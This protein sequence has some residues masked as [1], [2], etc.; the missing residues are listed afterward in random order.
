MK[1]IEA[2]VGSR[3]GRAG[4]GAASVAS[5]A[6]VKLP[7]QISWTAY[8]T[9]SS[10]YAQSVGIGQ[11][12]KKNYGTGLRI[13]PGKNDVARM[14]PLRSG[15]TPLCACGIAAYFA[16]EGAYFFGTKKWGPMKLYNLLNNI[17]D[18][19]YQLVAAGDA[20]IKKPSDLKGKRV[21]WVK[22]SPALNLNAGAHL[23]Y[24]GLTW[25]DVTKVVVSG[26]KQSAEAVIN[27]QADATYGSTVSGAYNKLAA[28][29][30]GLFWTALDMA[31]RKPGNV[32][33]P[34]LPGGARPWSRSASTPRRT[35]RAR[36]PIRA[37]SSPI[38]SSLRR[39]KDLTTSPTA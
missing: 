13:I 39:I 35:R 20:G 5:A 11:M 27:G 31:T 37:T 21:T 2:C 34:S 19:G 30:R 26:W 16:Q 24:A 14:V 28:S 12:L 33:R 4:I 36:S 15:Q 25:D 38:R 32:R 6:D 29:P 10:G 9:T 18:N 8:G 22:G 1:M 17:G 3:R 23:A 7:K